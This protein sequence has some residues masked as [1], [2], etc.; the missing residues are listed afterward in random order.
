M[1]PLAAPAT[2]TALRSDVLHLT[3]EVVRLASAEDTGDG[4]DHSKSSGGSPEAGTE[5]AGWAGA[6]PTASPDHCSRGV[7]KALQGA[8]C[9]DR[10]APSALE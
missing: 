5:A 2:A 9:P 4:A 6:W 8:P 3:S 10:P 1:C 7:R